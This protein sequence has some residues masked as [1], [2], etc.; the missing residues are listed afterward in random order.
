MSTIEAAM[1]L[2]SL[3]VVCGVIV[4][5]VATMSAH[6]VAVDTAGAAARSHALGVEHTPGRGE[7]SVTESD[8]LVTVV[9]TVP[10][11]LGHR[12]HEAVFPR[13]VP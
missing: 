2:G 10:A 4:G 9:A 13:E 6:L 1:G 8:G 11:P 12:T 7:V 3:V 5:A